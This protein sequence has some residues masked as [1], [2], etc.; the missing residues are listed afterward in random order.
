MPG[1]RFAATPTRRVTKKP[2]MG[3]LKKRDYRSIIA[4]C[5]SL[6]FLWGGSTLSAQPLTTV[7]GKVLDGTNREP[8]ITAS[9]SFVNTTTG[10]ITEADGSF[11]LTTREAVDSIL[12]SYLGYQ[13]KTLPL[14]RG[15]TQELTITLTPT[16]TLLQT[17]DITAKKERY[18]R[19]G[20]PAV[21]LIRNVIAHKNENRLD[22][23]DHY[24]YRKYEK[25]QL[26]MSNV[27]R[28]VVESKWLRG[29]DFVF[30]HLDTTSTG[31]V[32]LPVFFQETDSRVY[33]RKN[34]EAKKEYRSGLKV[35]NFDDETTS[36]TIY[37]LTS[38]LYQQVDVYQDQVLLF[39][40]RFV[41]P[42]AGIAPTFYH[43]YILDTIAFKGKQ[44]VNLAFVPASRFDP[45]FEGTLYIALDSSYQVIGLEMGVLK[46]A[47]LNFMEGVRIRQEF[48][49]RDS[50]WVVT[51]DELEAELKV[52]DELVGF[53]GRKVTILHDYRF[54]PAEDS[55]LYDTPG[56]EVIS[57]EGADRRDDAYWRGAR[58]QGLSGKEEAIYGMV[59][60]L[61]NTPLVKT[62]V[63]SIKALSMGYV[64]TGPVDIGSMLT[65]VSF[66]DV[67]GWRL[68]FGGKTN[69]DFDDQFQLRSYLAYGTRDRRLKF[70]VGMRYAFEKGFNPF[71]RH[72]LALKVE[73]DNQFPG[74][75]TYLA[76]ADNF[77]LSF[78][79]GVADKMLAY[80]QLR[81]DYYKQFPNN[82]S[83]GLVADRKT[84]EAAGNWSFDYYEEE[85]D[86]PATRS[87]ISTMETSLVL[88]Y[89]PN[90]KYFEGAHLRYIMP[91]RYPIFD[92]AYTHGWEGLFGGA[93][94]YHRLDLGISKRF[95]LS[96]LGFTDLY[97]NGG[98]V[99]G[100][101]L[102]YI[103][104]HIPRANQTLTFQT[105]AYNVMNFMEFVTDQY[106]ALQFSHNFDGYL[107]GKIPLLRRLKM[108]AI[109]GFKA[110]YGRISD[111]NNPE[112]DQSL[113][114][115][116]V[117]ADGVPET[118]SLG[119]AP[120]LEF[121]AGVSNIF[122]FFRL[123][124][125]RRLNYLHHPNLPGLFGV[126][127]SG[128]RIGLE[129][130][131]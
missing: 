7:R 91:G 98:K 71:P 97:L 14:R 60:T 94:A 79:T 65:F 27:S 115:F 64:R 78:R 57:T 19:K 76:S 16:S 131:F 41:S 66:N 29:I 36:E 55:T 4:A 125:V 111:K 37:N 83:I 121:S 8:L 2:D 49:R 53:A 12:V 35:T 128:L 96:G 32:L 120:Y 112:L 42:L 28:K 11:E 75:F 63:T 48:E 70:S 52:A 21:E 122:K 80:D 88:Q 54:G 118:Y 23:L 15:A 18:R 99:W 67:E 73:R 77:F 3:P 84:Q 86:Q 17:V 109:V 95:F 92:L 104:L 22:H 123:D 85:T 113:I 110:L 114:Q 90:A 24:S 38:R 51:R 34:P 72:F 89:A 82:F 13:S 40:R 9:V 61:K 129:L 47:N 130:T 106:M 33:Y 39:D 59:D 124:Y 56:G 26:N 68:K 69:G 30:E 10:V 117:N 102:P 45:G 58:P 119:D 25:M 108:R 93:F 1:C 74:Q 31:Q 44:A 107:L 103:L 6:F 101:R 126:R 62:V 46:T 127:G 43:F 87:S 50:V 105:Q 116:P 100:N 81:V 20:N 5:L